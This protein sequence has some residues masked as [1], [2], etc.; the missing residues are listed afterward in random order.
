[1]NKGSARDVLVFKTRF[2]MSINVVKSTKSK[3]SE[4]RNKHQLEPKLKENFNDGYE[5]DKVIL[6]VLRPTTTP[7]LKY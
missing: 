6:I 4:S 2:T 1:M 7:H 3:Y 5:D